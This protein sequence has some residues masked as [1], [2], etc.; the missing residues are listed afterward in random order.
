MAIISAAT[1]YKQDRYKCLNGVE[2][3]SKFNNDQ[4]RK[5]SRHPVKY[6]S[7]GSIPLKPCHPSSSL[8]LPR[9]KNEIPIANHHWQRTRGSLDRARGCSQRNLNH[10]LATTMPWGCITFPRLV[11]YP[12]RASPPQTCSSDEALHS[13]T[14]A[15]PI[16]PGSAN[17]S[18]ESS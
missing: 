13:L 1:C 6:P 5:I 2:M 14:S 8:K 17:L 12:R 7:P 11:T 16:T 4:L 9:N 18:A 10:N 3:I 15:V